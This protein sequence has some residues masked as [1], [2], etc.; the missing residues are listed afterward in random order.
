[1]RFGYN[2]RIAFDLT[3]LYDLPK[4]SLAISQSFVNAVEPLLGNY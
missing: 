2:R 3:T 4:N 1:M